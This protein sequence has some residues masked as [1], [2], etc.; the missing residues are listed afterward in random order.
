MN[1]ENEISIFRLRNNISVL[2]IV[3]IL[4]KF[5]NILQYYLNGIVL[6][7]LHLQNYVQRKLK[8]PQIYGSNGKIA[9]Q[10]QLS[11]KLNLFSLA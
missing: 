9:V 8:S 11:L 2:F 1:L 4:V 10:L 7:L 5:F 6:A 3:S